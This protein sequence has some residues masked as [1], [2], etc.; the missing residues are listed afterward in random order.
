MSVCLTS[1]IDEN[2]RQCPAVRR[3]SSSLIDGIVKGESCYILE[4]LLEYNS[5]TLKKQSNGYLFGLSMAHI[6]IINQI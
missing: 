1:D 4:F 5:F 6:D 2:H 3:F